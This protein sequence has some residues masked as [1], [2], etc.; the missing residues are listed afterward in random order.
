[1]FDSG[2]ATMVSSLVVPSLSLPHR[3]LRLLLFFI[4]CAL[5]TVGEGVSSMKL[6]ASLSVNRL[7]SNGNDPSLL[8]LFYIQHL[9]MIESF[10]YVYYLPY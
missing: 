4:A 7:S 5:R 9:P 8:T 2:W 6:A 1:M 3:P 10:L